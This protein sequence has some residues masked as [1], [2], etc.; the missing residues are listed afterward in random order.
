M[1]SKPD[2]FVIVPPPIYKDGFSSIN[3]TLSN[4]ILP[5]LIPPLAKECGVEDD[6]IVNLHNAMGGDNADAPQFYCDGRHCDGYHP[7]DEGQ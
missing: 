6:Q 1:A 4:K 7:I 2:V 5:S 3:T